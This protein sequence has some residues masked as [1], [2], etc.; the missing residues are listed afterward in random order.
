MGEEY[1]DDSPFYFFADYRQEQLANG[2]RES[3]QQQFA[4]FNW[5][6]EAPDPLEPA[7]F[8]DCILKWGQRHEPGHRELLEWHRQ[9]ITLRKTH[10]LLA[11]C[12]RKYLHADLL[13][14]TG[15]AILRYSADRRQQLLVLLNFSSTEMATVIPN[16]S[17]NGEPYT[18]VLSSPASAGHLDPGRP[19]T[20]LP[21]S[22]SVY[23]MN[24]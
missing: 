6:K 20:L 4:G 23:E 21:W 13:G 10:P 17:L 1:G 22:V 5:E 24:A 8:L 9:L 12:S 18:K 2:L 3:R 16:Y 19:V 7:T 15:L 11:G 14:P